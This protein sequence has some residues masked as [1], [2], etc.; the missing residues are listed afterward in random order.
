MDAASRMKEAKKRV[1][2]EAEQDKVVVAERRR[3]RTA[4]IN[5]RRVSIV[6]YVKR[7]M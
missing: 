4:R 1:G 5:V 6:V 7:D 2:K 3:A